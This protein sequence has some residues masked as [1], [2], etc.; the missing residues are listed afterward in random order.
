MTDDTLYDL[1][2]E[3]QVLGG[4]ILGGATA[5]AEADALVQPHDYYRGLHGE[6][7][8]ALITM[9]DR[10]EPLDPPAVTEALGRVSPDAWQLAVD[11]IADTA[12]AASIA[13]WAH[14][15]ADYA[16]RRSIVEAARQAA[17]AAADPS[18][19]VDGVLSDTVQS[20]TRSRATGGVWDRDAIIEAGL[21]EVG[22]P[23][24]LGWPAPWSCLAE[25]WRI[26]P[27]WVHVVT[28]F[29]SSGKSA[30]VDDL[31]VRLGR[32]GVRTLMWSP[33]AAPTGRHALRLA[34]IQAGKPSRDLPAGEAVVALEWVADRIRWIDHDQARTLPQILA[35]AS[36]ARH[37]GGCDLLV[38]DPFT[39][40][41]KWDSAGGDEAWDRMLDRQLTR[42]RQW[43]RG[44]AVAVIVV[45]HPRSKERRSD[46]S[47]PVATISDLHGGA[48]WRNRLDSCVSVWRDEQHEI[49][50]ARQ[51]VQV[52]VQKIR[53]NGAGGVMG[54]RGDLV[55]LD[56]GRYR[57]SMLS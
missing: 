11:L 33:E 38:I 57:P 15:V 47:Y 34:G 20:L 2:A 56:N 24:H 35:Q 7:H 45:A 31:V 23:E 50:E 37:D 10:R 55:R 12:T 26:V 54:Y 19:D 27:G 41:E 40:V 48:L 46:G 28:G 52:H 18:C 17:A 6:V 22:R 51:E 25:Q 39:D 4:M 49:P 5:I 9:R 32:D 21:S 13:H 53:E 44:H 30:L 42:L 8:A 1:T 29:P 3:R 43:A 16:R 36:A 14:I